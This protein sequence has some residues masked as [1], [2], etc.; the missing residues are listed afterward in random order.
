M[1]EDPKRFDAV[2]VGAG[3]AGLYM[4][5]K[6]AGIGL[7][8]LGLERGEDVGGVWYWNRYPGARCDVESMQYSYSFDPDLEQDW[9]WSERFAAQPEILA[10]AAHVA[11]RFDLRRHIRFG[12]ALAAARYDEGRALWRLEAGGQRLEAR[13]LIMATGCLSAAKAPDLPGYEDYRGRL[14]HTGAWPRDPVS[15][16]GERV[17]VI[18]TGSSGLQA[19]PVIA[20][21]AAHLTVFQRTP[22]F[23]VPARNAPMDPAH[24]A[25]WKAEYPRLRKVAR[26][27]APSGTVYDFAVKSALEAT[28]EER[29]AEFEVRWAKGGVNFMH[30]YNDILRNQ[31]SNDHAAE[32]IRAKIREIVREPARA[33]ALLP[34]GHPVGAK[35]IC[36]DSGYHATFNRAN[37]DLVDL[38]RTPIEALTADGL[39]TIAADYAFDSIVLATGYDAM[40]GALLAVPIEGRGGRTLREHWAAG[41]RAH[42]GLMMEGFPNLFAL[43]APGSPSVLVN[44]MVAIEQHVEWVARCIGDMRAHGLATI[45]PTVEAEEAWVRHVADLADGTLFPKAASWY[46]GANVPGK[47]RV[48]MVYVAG[49]GPYRRH[50]DEIAASGYTGFILTP[51]PSRKRTD[52]GRATGAA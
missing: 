38:R 10:Y 8:V 23:S 9:R 36:V 31:A 11:E 50:C 47:P 15:F 45:E 5:H 30:A 14:L 25:Y 44:V 3:F 6:L 49:I 42:L 16:R 4:I 35:R 48:F 32:F 29:L 17:A 12:T 41:P 51:A 22:N 24:E 21:E 18:G 33:E 28:D 37:V 7:H 39:R 19:I 34:R 43:T 40:T 1:S 46:M 13:F 20:E 52:V 27:T 26:E 2:V